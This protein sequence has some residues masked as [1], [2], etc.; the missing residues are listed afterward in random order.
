MTDSTHTPVPKSSGGAMFGWS[1][2]VILMIIGMVV[3]I[4]CTYAYNNS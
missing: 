2:V 4:Y 3:Y 1:V